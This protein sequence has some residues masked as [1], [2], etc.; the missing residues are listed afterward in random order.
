MIPESLQASCLG[1]RMMLYRPNSELVHVAYMLYALQSPRVR[2]YLDVI[3]GGSTV[4]HVKVGEIRS[5]R[6]PCPHLKEQEIIAKALDG[7]R[8]HLVAVNEQCAKLRHQKY[9]L[10]HD[11]LTG[12]VRVPLKEA[13]EAI[14]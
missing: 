5:L 10:M 3:S 4:G 6:L 9:G 14:L 11:L 8:S 2:K 13:K 1:Q 7:V 12:L